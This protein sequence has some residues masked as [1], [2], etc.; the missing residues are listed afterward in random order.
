M[1]GWW[2]GCHFYTFSHILGFS[3]S[4]LTFIFFLGVQPNHQPD[5]WLD[6]HKSNMDNVN[7]PARSW[8][9]WIWL[10]YLIKKKD[11]WCRIPAHCNSQFPQF[12]WTGVFVQHVS[13]LQNWRF[14]VSRSN[15][16]IC[17]QFSQNGRRK[18][19]FFPQKILK[20]GHL[21]HPYPNF[22]PI[23][24]VWIHQL[25]PIGVP[26][27]MPAIGFRRG[28]GRRGKPC[29]PCSAARPVKSGDDL[30]VHVGSCIVVKNGS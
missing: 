24:M 23:F 19:R 12:H 25:N 29:S 4:Q 1:S 13:T 7:I 18:R 2:F 15:A 6:H 21:K 26:F 16:I 14:I 9:W 5:K 11:L 20:F 22:L 8:S 27:A 10:I 3:S 28:L 17:H 30:A